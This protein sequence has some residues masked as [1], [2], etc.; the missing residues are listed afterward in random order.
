MWCSQT[1]VSVH[2]GVRVGW[3]GTVG[4]KCC[5]RRT[6]A[7]AS[8]GGL[9]QVW[10]LGSFSWLGCVK[11]YERDRGCLESTRIVENIW[12]REYRRFF[13]GCHNHILQHRVAL[14]AGTRS[15][16]DSVN[17]VPSLSSP[18]S[19]V[20]LPTISRF[21]HGPGLKSCEGGRSSAWGTLLSLSERKISSRTWSP[22]LREC[23]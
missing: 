21:I 15:S 4:D 22:A 14:D 11:A 17:L 6:E 8:N 5:W 1:C 3:G 12:R 9:Y 16:V 2:G 23:W 18:C 7:K 10:G 19:H 20:P 13:P